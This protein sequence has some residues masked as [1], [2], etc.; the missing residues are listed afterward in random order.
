MRQL[1]RAASSR[2]VGHALRSTV[3]RTPT[4]VAISVEGR[5]LTFAQLDAES[6]RLANA[7]MGLGATHGTRIGILSEN[8]LE[9]A[10]A[11]YA[12]AKIG[13]IVAAFNWRLTPS[14]LKA[15]MATTD[16]GTVFV[17]S[18]FRELYMSAAAGLARRA[19][20]SLDGRL[21]G[22]DL[23]LD[24][25]LSAAS[26]RDP[27]REVD[28][29]D[30]LM[31]LYT[32]GST[33]TPK[34]AAISHRAIVARAMALAADMGWRDIHTFIGW[35]PLF[36]TGGADYLLISG[37]IGGRYQIVDGPRAEVIAATLRDYP[38]V[39]LFLP[40][41]GIQKVLDEVARTGPP[42]DLGRVGSM[43]DLI[44]PELIAA[45]TTALR[46]PFLNSFG[47]TE[48]GCYPSPISTIP[49][50]VA[51]TRLSKRPSALCDVRIVDEFGDEVPYETPGEM[52]LR[53]PMLFSGYWNNDEVNAEDF[54]SGWFHTG[55]L[56]IR[57][58]DG[59]LDYYDRKKYM[60]KSGGENIY[61]AEIERLLLE[62]DG[63]DEAIVVKKR[64]PQWG[65]VP[66]V[67]IAATA[68]ARVTEEDLRRHIEPKLS[69]YKLP[70]QYVFLP[71]ERFPRNVTGKVVRRELERL[72]E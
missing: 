63:V 7:L 69:R 4:A 42:R 20:V 16:P 31:I 3:L 62:C 34:G 43:A 41:G 67:F 56:M 8:R 35:A 68:G 38:V 66:V 40:P 47:S 23:A 28:A 15:V 53:G 21:T 33:G 17:S 22:T 1:T 11:Y 51:P 58:A 64:D 72:V 39:W 48:A 18:R 27:G 10:L 60:I 45:T 71:I 24:R 54:R 30:I 19:V 55:D 12:A 9:Y 26:D 65:E 32:S 61:P 36:H 59:T 29:E 37:I 50:G 2:T 52:L 25:L 6:N 57:H 14:E 44:P 70:R 13:A 49:I 46:A 5:Q